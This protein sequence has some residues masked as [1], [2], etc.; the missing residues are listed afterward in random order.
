MGTPAY[1]SPEQLLGREVDHRTDIFALAVMLIESLTGRRPFEGDTFTDLLRAH[2]TAYR[3]PGSSPAALAL[4]N[5]L[6][7][8][9]EIDPAKRA[10]SVAALKS[11]IVPLLRACQPEDFLLSTNPAV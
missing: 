11:E 10:A 9:L 3:F 8:C 1:M 7:Q 2:Q 5:Q 4:G 6:Q